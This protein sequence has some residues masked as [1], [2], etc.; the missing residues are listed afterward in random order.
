MFCKYCGRQIAD[1]S[2][3]CPGCGNQLNSAQET[4]PQA[5]ASSYQ[6][7]PPTQ[8][9]PP[10][11][12]G[13]YPNYTP[14]TPPPVGGYRPN[15]GYQSP[16]SVSAFNGY[17]MKWYK[18]LIYFSLFAS[19]VG[20][21]ISGILLIAGK[22]YGEE[23]ELIY[24]FFGELRIVDLLSGIVMIALGVMAIF[25]R[26]KLVQFRKDAPS[27]LLIFL[28]I[29][30][31]HSAARLILTAALAGDIFFSSSLAGSYVLGLVLSVLMIALNNVYFKKRAALFVN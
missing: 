3:F 25:V 12:P 20:G 17:P 19:C 14:T 6:Q 21:V 2:L 15:G 9:T 13:S 29:S 10:S 18:F 1:G 16:S 31:A 5:G 24:L 26:Q 23:S 7:T 22:A 4:P 30:T 8:Q 11:Q 27:Y 28:S